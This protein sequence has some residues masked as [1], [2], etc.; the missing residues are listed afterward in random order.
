MQ[1]NNNSIVQ[2]INSTD[3]LTFPLALP[4]KKKKN[5]E[6]NPIKGSSTSKSEEIKLTHK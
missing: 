1:N 6:K 3:N 4:K 5:F 2:I